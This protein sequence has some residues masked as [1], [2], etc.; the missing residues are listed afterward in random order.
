[1]T[2]ED[3]LAQMQDDYDIITEDYQ[4][5]LAVYLR[6]KREIDD[7]MADEREQYDNKIKPY[8][9]KVEYAKV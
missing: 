3:E 1:M 8:L 9:G 5:K 2:K 4:K 6:I 7:W